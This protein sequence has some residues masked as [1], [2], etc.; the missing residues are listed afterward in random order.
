MTW[1]C[2]V[3]GREAK[4]VFSLE[5]KEICSWGCSFGW[6]V[7]EKWDLLSFFFVVNPSTE[8]NARTRN[9]ILMNFRMTK[10]SPLRVTI[11]RRGWGVLWLRRGYYTDSPNHEIKI[12]FFKCNTVVLKI[13]NWSTIELALWRTGEVARCI[14]ARTG[15]ERRT[16]RRGYC[17][18]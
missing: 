14:F 3:P 4:P 10:G 9:S 16:V 7:G 17:P 12:N 8:L 15:E 11:W 5:Y 13:D 2:M 1:P 6:L 18:S